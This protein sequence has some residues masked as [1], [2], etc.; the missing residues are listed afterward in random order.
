MYKMKTKLVAT[1]KS[2]AREAASLVLFYIKTC[3]QYKDSKR[4]ERDVKG[5]NPVSCL[6]SEQLFLRNSD[7]EKIKQEVENLNPWFYELEIFG[8]KVK[9][10]VYPSKEEK[11]LNTR[12]LIN[13]QMYRKVLLV[14]EVTKRFDFAGAHILDVACNCGYWSSLYITR[15]DADSIV[16][17]EGRDLFIKQADLYYKSLGIQDKAHFVHDNIMEYDYDRWG[18]DAFDFILCAG[19]LY[20]VRNQE[21]LLKKISYVNRKVLVIDTRVSEKEEEFVEPK[22]LWFNAIEET[23]D[24]KVPTKDNLINMLHKLGYEIEIIPPRFKT[25]HGVSGWDNYAAGKR[26]CMFCKKG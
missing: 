3:L 17:I 20:H 22:N 6:P 15:Y 14:N 11:S 23:R 19:I 16:G 24:K 10:G 9:P 25:I 4:I 5:L 21:E 2:W 1:T 18:R 26:I 13:R 8:V 12:G 7:R